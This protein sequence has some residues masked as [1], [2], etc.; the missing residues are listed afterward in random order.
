MSDVFKKLSGI[1]VSEGTEKKDKLTYLPWTKAW[2]I[3]SK[4]YPNACY[5]IK[6]FNDGLPYV[7]DEK[8]GYMVFT[9]VTIEGDTK[10]MWLPVMDGKN[11]A[12]KKEAYTYKTKY[13][14]K[15]VEAATM[16]DI[17][18]TI[19]RCLVKNIAVF[20]LGLYIYEKEDLPTDD[21]NFAL[22]DDLKS[23]LEKIKTV[24]DLNIFYN[25]NKNK[26][27]KSLLET[28][29]KKKKEFKNGTN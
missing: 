26:M 17:N 19:M 6:K 1:N 13:D 24:A 29:A 15:R 3:L 4:E 8:T 10:E 5:E 14:T 16:F 2:S 12:M 22:T 23:D 25:E 7:F 18:K 9:K 11:K 21:N 28:L 27:T 20:G